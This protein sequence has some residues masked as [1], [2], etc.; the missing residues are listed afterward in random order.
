MEIP[1]SESVETMRTGRFP[2]VTPEIHKGL[3]LSIASVATTQ[4]PRPIEIAE[5]GP[6]LPITVVM[7]STVEFLMR[8]KGDVVAVGSVA[9]SR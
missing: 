8:A 6:L 3:W 1:V 9:S 7:M 2:F 5:V 4:Y